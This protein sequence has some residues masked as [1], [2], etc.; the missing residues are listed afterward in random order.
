MSTSA[1]VAGAL[2]DV[3]LAQSLSRFSHVSNKPHT[4][5]KVLPRSSVRCQLGSFSFL[6]LL[7]LS[8]P[9]HCCPSVPWGRCRHYIFLGV[10][11]RP[12]RPGSSAR[13]RG[14]FSGVESR[15]FCPV[16]L[17]EDVS[18][19]LE[20]RVGWL[21][22]AVPMAVVCKCAWPSEEEENTG[23]EVKAVLPR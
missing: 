19:A 16:T 22:Q 10:R 13:G 3:S 4:S 6:S 7:G 9:R 18:S 1:G 5:L 21:C 17:G 11:A 15:A 12:G 8:V 14:R 23:I 20:R 2:G